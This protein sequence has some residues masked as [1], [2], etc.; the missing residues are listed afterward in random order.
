MS[1]PSLILSL[2][3]VEE[4]LIFFNA[5]TFF[6]CSLLISLSCDKYNN[7][8]TLTIWQT[9]QGRH[10][11]Y[12]A[13]SQST[14][15][16]NFLPSFPK[17]PDLAQ[18]E[19]NGRKAGPPTWLLEWR[20]GAYIGLS[21]PLPLLLMGSQDPLTGIPKQQCILTWRAPQ[22]SNASFGGLEEGMQWE[23]EI[24]SL[25]WNPY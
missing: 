2:Q 8:P 1:D 12:P 21:L 4:A 25:T 24:K 18:C 10:K 9:H 23:S 13:T 7:L 22:S 15:H 3:C 5:K 20:A 14:G 11:T 17:R 16:T 19:L 6:L